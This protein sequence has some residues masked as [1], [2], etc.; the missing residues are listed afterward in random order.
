[1][2]VKLR[3]PGMPMPDPF[4]DALRSLALCLALGAGPS[5]AQDAD[6]RLGLADVGQISLDTACALE[7]AGWDV[8]PYDARTQQNIV[9]DGAGN[10]IDVIGG[11]FTVFWNGDSRRVDGRGRDWDL[12]GVMLG[13][14]SDTAAVAAFDRAGIVLPDPVTGDMPP[15]PATSGVETA[16]NDILAGDPVTLGQAQMVA[17]LHWAGGFSMG[18]G[19]TP[20]DGL[21][22]V[23]GAFRTAAIGG[24]SAFG[25]G[26]A[27]QASRALSEADA[28]LLP[29]C[30][31]NAVR[32]LNTLDESLALTFR[33]MA[34]TPFM[35][36]CDL[37]AGRCRCAFAALSLYH[38]DLATRPY[39]PS[40]FG[41]RGGEDS[42][43]ALGVSSCR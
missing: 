27:P 42:S 8:P 41:R 39:D 19:V 21:R 3:L 34:D 13:D 25:S 24:L 36:G 17:A 32:Y 12:L 14:R 7:R 37:G 4:R 5:A 38:D 23:S 43:R 16:L 35:R 33:A 31:G 20:L 22:Q 28:V 18:C 9:I 11:S 29:P 10:R 2:T 30:K 1:M 26:F 15:A 6:C 40:L